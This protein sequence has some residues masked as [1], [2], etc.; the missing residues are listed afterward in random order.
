MPSGRKAMPRRR[1]SYPHIG[2]FRQ[3]APEIELCLRF[4]G[5]D[6]NGKPLYDQDRIIP[7]ARLDGSW[8]VHGS[9]VIISQSEDGEIWAQN[10]R[11]LLEPGSRDDG[12][13]F[14][15]FLA[16]RMDAVRDIFRVLRENGAEGEISVYAEHCGRGVQNGVGVSRLPQMLYVFEVSQ[17]AGE[18]RKWLS[19]RMAGLVSNHDARIYNAFEFGAPDPVEIDF[20]N[21]EEAAGRMNEATLKVAA[22]CPVAAFFGI[23]GAGEGIVWRWRDGRTLKRMKTKSEKF[24]ASLKHAK[25]LVEVNPVVARTAEEFAARVLGGNRLEQ[26]LDE[27]FGGKPEYPDIGRYLKWVADDVEREEGDVLALMEKKTRKAAMGRVHGIAKRRFVEAC[28]K[29]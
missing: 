13:A 14:L 19:D 18:G 7:A 21:P 17:E 11:T 20:G 16:E 6:G 1:V 27:L 15:P 8:K 10:R 23:D 24:T 29:N 2:E 22:R 9:C 5:R 3:I 25:K 4:A 26:G 12:H 28:G